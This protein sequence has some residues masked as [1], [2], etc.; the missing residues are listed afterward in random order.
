MNET[1]NLDNET[2]EES[3]VGGIIPRLDPQISPLGCYGLGKGLPD[4]FNGLTLLNDKERRPG[5]T[6]SDPYIEKILMDPGYCIK[7][8]I[9]Y[10]FSYAAL[11]GLNLLDGSIGCRC[12]S[13][14]ALQSYV[15]V[16]DKSSAKVCN[17]NCNFTVPGGNITY[18]CGGKSAYTVYNA[19]LPNYEQPKMITIE[20][21]LDIMNDLTLKKNYKGCVKDSQI[22]G[23]RTLNRKCNSLN[24]MTIDQ[25]INYCREGNFKYGGLEAMTQCFCDNFYDSIGRL[26]GPEHCSASCPGNNS[27]ICGGSWVL[28]IYEITPIPNN[29]N[30]APP[31]QATATIF[32]TPSAVSSTITTTPSYNIILFAIGIYIICI[33]RRFFNLQ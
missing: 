5:L 27:E 6:F 31:P 21:K 32:P 4:S 19:I 11:G 2:C 33:Y 1:T 30:Q 14:K 10:K 22:C 12:G 15:R 16:P 13:E 7:H 8:C 3:C 24:T 26:V 17:I 20:K 28:S 25:C 23:T 18:P 29:P 9:D